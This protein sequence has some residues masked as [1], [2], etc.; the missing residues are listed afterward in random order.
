MAEENKNEEVSCCTRGDC[1]CDETCVDQLAT[2]MCADDDNHIHQDGDDKTSAKVTCDEKGG[3]EKLRSEDKFTEIPVSEDIDDSCAKGCCSSLPKEPKARS[4]IPKPACGGH[5]SIARRKMETLASF[6]CICKAMIE[7]GLQSCCSTK[8]TQAGQSPR[9]FG[10]RRRSSGSIHKGTTPRASS[11]GGD[12]AN[13]KQSHVAKASSKVSVVSSSCS[14][15]CCG[16]KKDDLVEARGGKPTQ[17]SVSLA[18][19]RKRNFKASNASSDCRDSCCGGESSKPAKG[20]DEG[21]SCCGD[22]CCNEKG[23]A[24]TEANAREGCCEGDSPSASRTSLAR[25]CQDSCCGDATEAVQTTRR[26]TAVSL[27]DAVIELAEDQSSL[28]HAVLL[29]EGMTCT[30]CEVKLIRV[31]QALPKASNP[32]VSIILG[33]AEFDYAGHPEELKALISIVEQRTGFSAKEV[34]PTTKRILDLTISPNLMEKLMTTPLP[35]G[36]YDVAKLS[37]HVARVT[38]DPHTVGA[39]S[40]LGSFDDFSVSLAP[41]PRDPVVTAGINHV[42]AL[43]V[44]TIIS[45]ILTIPVL[46]MTWAPLPDHRR[47][48]SIA[49]LVLATIVQFGIAGHFYSRAFKSLIFSRVVEIDLLIVLSTSAAYIYSVVAFAFDMA[50]K[51]L[52]QEQFFETST[53]LVTLIL[54]GQLISAFARHRAVEAISLRSLQ[55]NTAL[56]VQFNGREEEIDGRLLHLGDTIKV[57]PDSSIITD[58]IVTQGQSEVDESMMTGESMPVSKRQGSIVVAGTVNGPSTLHIKITRLPGDNTISDIASMVDSARFSRAKVQATVDTVC[59]YFVPCV[60]LITGIVFCIWVGIGLGKRH[61]DSGKAVITALT[62]AIAVLAISCPCAIGLAVPMVILVASGVAA[63]KM[64]LVFKSATTIE[65]ARKVS[66]VVFDKTGTLTTGK[67]AVIT[68]QEFEVE[69]LPV[70]IGPSSVILGLV[71]SSKHPVARAVASHLKTNGAIVSKDL[72]GVEMVTGSGIRASL[73]GSPLL[74]GNP[75]WLSLETHP[76]VSVMLNDGLTT[77]CVSFNGHLLAAFSLADILRPEAHAVVATLRAQN[78]EISLLSGDHSVAVN[79]VASGLGIPPDH[80][81]SG[82]LPQDKQAYIKELT[83]AGQRVLFCGDGTNDAIAL[84]QASIGVHMSSDAGGIAAASA[85]DVVLL[86]P[87]LTGITSLLSLSQSVYRRIVFNF[88]WSFVYNLVAMLFASGAFVN[89]RV[90]PAYAG[91][92]EMVSVL[93]VVVGALSIKWIGGAGKE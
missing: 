23:D 91:L 71:E 4:K 26:Q 51:P 85:A 21:D 29:I 56:V 6:G 83:N 67:L 79:R 90:A 86:H 76:D 63:K 32:E 92:G 22:P 35:N 10:A 27:G 38:Y 40:V 69:G 33:R 66:H 3:D 82:C 68:Y 88:A 28:S 30:G 58:G 44:R 17:S 54:V 70:G 57:G 41:E 48:Y 89:V 12:E 5:Q 73:A 50:G 77:F 49:S 2:A 87:S 74:G 11:C 39:R 16:G 42:R 93:P 34:G 78:I 25:S 53:L 37:K 65:E 9:S 13:S 15:G 31:L 61:D 7:R 60:L 75:R 52:E 45:A 43:L 20:A 24:G 14:S 72:K 62:Y 59:G 84:A 80:V 81:R 8:I 18:G 19:L 36:V 47:E 1:C 64:S 46:I 55:Q